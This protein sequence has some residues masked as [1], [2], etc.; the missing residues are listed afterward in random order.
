MQNEAFTVDTFDKLLHRTM[1]GYKKI[2]L[3]PEPMYDHCIYNY[4]PR[5]L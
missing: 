5:A 4:A 2:A 3:H 1:S